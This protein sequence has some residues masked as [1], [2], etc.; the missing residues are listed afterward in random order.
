MEWK[1]EIEEIR[2]I[3]ALMEKQ[4]ATP[5]YYPL[6]LNALVQ[7]CNQKSSRLPV[8]SY[9]E[10]TVRN[11]VTNLYD[12]ALVSSIMASDRRVV[13]YGQRLSNLLSCSTPETAILCVLFLRGPQT[14]GEI[15]G[16]TTRLHP[17][18]SLAEVTETLELMIERE[19][20][21]LVRQLERQPG[22]KE[23]RFMHEFGNSDL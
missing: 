9:S 13:R 8:V 16:R 14:P 20:F 10:S 6:S 2:I 1:L 11:N 15:K 23:H 4:M 17:F 19:E 7:A 22:R 3:G 12:R 21:A 18:E 5:D